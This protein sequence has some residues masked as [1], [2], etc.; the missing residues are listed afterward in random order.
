[1]AGVVFY[2][3]NNDVDVYSGRSVDLD[4]WYLASQIPGDID[5]IIVINKTDTHLVTPNTR[6]D[7]FVAEDLPRLENAVYLDPKWGDSL[8]D[9]DHAEVDW[10]VFGPA[11]GWGER[12]SDKQ[13][14]NIPH[15]NNVHCHSQHVMTTV[16]F[17][18]YG[19]MHQ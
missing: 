11:S 14:I 6:L 18:R 15:T 4:A 2:F 16:M 17:H 12:D 8:W 3:E 19:S 13:Y 7:F 5:R 1:M 9:L 10:Y